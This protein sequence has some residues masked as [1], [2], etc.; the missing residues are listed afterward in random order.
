MIH[1]LNNGLVF[2]VTELIDMQGDSSSVGRR[3]SRKNLSPGLLSSPLSKPFQLNDRF[4]PLVYQH[5]S[6]FYRLRTYKRTIY[7]EAGKQG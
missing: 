7:A 6:S 2:L 1:F 4:Q 5:V 3:F